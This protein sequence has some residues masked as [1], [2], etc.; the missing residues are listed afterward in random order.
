MGS[1]HTLDIRQNGLAFAIVT[2]LNRKDFNQ[3]FACVSHEG[4]GTIIATLSPIFLLV[5]DHDSCLNPLVRHVTSPP[6]SE[7]DVVEFSDSVPYS[8][9]KRSRAV[10]G[11]HRVLPPYVSLI[12]ESPLGRT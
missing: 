12:H 7:D 9:P 6:H 3:Y 5:R 2:R 11:D 1:K 4:V 8:R 10:P